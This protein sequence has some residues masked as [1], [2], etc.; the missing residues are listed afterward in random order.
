MPQKPVGE[1]ERLSLS[2]RRALLLR[3]HTRFRKQFSTQQ[4]FC[5]THTNIVMDTRGPRDRNR[6]VLS[7]SFHMCVSK[8]PNIDNTSAIYNSA[9][10]AS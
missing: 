2:Y 1:G 10:E 5:N 4:L 9:S 3:W 7:L 8:R 6:S